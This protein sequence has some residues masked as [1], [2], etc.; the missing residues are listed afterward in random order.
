VKLPIIG[1]TLIDLTKY[2]IVEILSIP[3]YDYQVFG[4]TQQEK[5]PIINNRF[6]MLDC[7]HPFAMTADLKF[8]QID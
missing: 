3:N 2:D 5:D 7:R 8:H 6:A 4:H 1:D